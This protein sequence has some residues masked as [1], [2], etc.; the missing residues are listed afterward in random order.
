M[1]PRHLLRS[2]MALLGLAAL[3]LTTG[4]AEAVDAETDWE[5]SLS[6][7]SPAGSLKSVSSV[8]EDLAWAVGAGEEQ[9][10]VMRWDGEE[11]SEDGAPGL[12]D[13]VWEWFSVSAV[14][15]DDVW[16][17]GMAGS[18]QELVHFD[19][20]RWTS[21]ALPGPT[22]SGWLE[23]PIEAVDGRLFRGGS[24]LHTYSDGAWQTFE[25]PPL[26]NIRDIDALSADAAYATGMQYPVDGG[27]P[28]TYHWD[29]TTWTLM[30]E[31][32]ARTGTDVDEIAA[33]SASNVYVAGWAHGPHADPLL[34]SVLHW[35]GTVWQDITGSLSD[36]YLDAIAPDG[37]GGLWATGSDQTEP[38]HA[39]PVFWHYDGT[40][41]SKESGAL[42]P[43]GE[44]RWPNYTFYDL[45][46]VGGTGAFWAVGDYQMPMDENSYQ[47]VN[48]LIERSLAPLP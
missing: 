11:W 9:G 17:S 45:A 48:A 28:V 18:D 7:I 36:L 43:D 22:H 37:Q 30:E 16:A 19:G 8:S 23:V 1:I 2:T 35:N 31:V 42:A 15:A 38:A 47:R 13:D 3:L 25:L 12:P 5:V 6:G 32:P 24:G 34:P 33:V 14:S 39:E 20:E 26:V 44:T 27:H 21:V 46:P 40:T 4:A 29:G 10:V 41:W